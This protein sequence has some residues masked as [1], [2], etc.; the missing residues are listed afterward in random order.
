M[1]VIKPPT[2]T[3]NISAPDAPNTN[4]NCGCQPN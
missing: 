2:D 3:K 1:F 4:C